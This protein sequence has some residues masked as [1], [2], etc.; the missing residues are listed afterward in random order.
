VEEREL[1]NNHQ[2]RDPCGYLSVMVVSMPPGF[3]LSASSVAAIAGFPVD[4]W[5]G[6]DGGGGTRGMQAV[7]ADIAAADIYGV[8][9]EERIAAPA[10]P[11]S[12]RTTE[13]VVVAVALVV[14]PAGF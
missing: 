2:R 11:W 4:P 3:R 10:V 8:C 12:K 5:I 1:A 13:A 9:T 7:A 6:D 14:A